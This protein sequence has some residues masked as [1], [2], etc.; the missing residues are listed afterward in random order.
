MHIE[1]EKKFLVYDS[2]FKEKAAGSHHMRQGYVAHEEG[3]SVRVR[4]SDGKA[5]LTI[6]GPGDESGMSRLEWEKEIPVSDASDLLQLCIGG[7]IDKTRYV[8]PVGNLYGTADN[9]GFNPD[10]FYEV[11]EFHGVN[12][13]LII[14]EIELGSEDEPFFKPSWLGPEVTGDKRYYNAFLS[15][16]PFEKWE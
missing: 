4:I 10:R 7:I 1:T 3:R 13:G 14:A 9:P 8:I 12:K 6:K 5:Y 11:D 15:K 2:S 16:H